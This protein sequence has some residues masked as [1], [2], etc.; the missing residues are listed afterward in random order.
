MWLNQPDASLA[1]TRH[2]VSPHASY[3]QGISYRTIIRSSQ[4]RVGVFGP[5]GRVALVLQQGPS[6]LMTL[7]MLTA[8]RD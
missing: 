5:P 1:A 7:L 2:I 4:S 6:T 8:R 3:Q